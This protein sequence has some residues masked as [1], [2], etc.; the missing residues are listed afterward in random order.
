[1]KK[2]ILLSFAVITAAI[3][4]SCG[5][6]MYKTQSAGKDNISHIIVVKELA[7]SSY[8]NVAVIV[9]NQTHTYSHVHRIKAKR[10]A[11]PV[12]VEPGKHNVKVTVNGVVVTDENI[13]LGLQET[14]MIVLR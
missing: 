12:I 10:K 9:D 11:H 6:H 3:F 5:P 7:S 14:K 2:I 4:S 13:F 8:A 1:M